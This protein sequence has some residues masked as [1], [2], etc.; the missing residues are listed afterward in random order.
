ML[1]GLVSLKRNLTKT[2]HANFT[3]CWRKICNYISLLKNREHREKSEILSMS[4]LTVFFLPLSLSTGTHLIILL[5]TGAIIALL[6]TLVVIP[7]WAQHL[8]MLHFI[9]IVMKC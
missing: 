4:F 1:T 8:H 7:A 3:M 6:P 2:L 5:G 9:M